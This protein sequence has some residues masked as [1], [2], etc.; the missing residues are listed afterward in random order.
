MQ[1][2]HGRPKKVIDTKTA[3]SFFEEVEGPI[4]KVVKPVVHSVGSLGTNRLYKFKD[5]GTCL[6]TY[7]G[8]NKKPEEMSFK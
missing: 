8:N 4:A 6:V 7:S 2:K 1:I 3:D 5:G